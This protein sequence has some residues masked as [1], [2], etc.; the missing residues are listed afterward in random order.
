MR[1]LLD[2]RSAVILSR[3]LCV[4]CVRNATARATRAVG[5]VIRY[6]IGILTRLRRILTKILS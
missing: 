2:H 4:K 1:S 5:R 3:Y 6:C